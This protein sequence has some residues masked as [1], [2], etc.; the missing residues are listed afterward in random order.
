MD[1]CNRVQLMKKAQNNNTKQKHPQ[2]QNKKAPIKKPSQTTKNLSNLSV[3]F[4]LYFEFY[5]FKNVM[6]VQV[7]SR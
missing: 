5:M 1:F 4:Y 3:T 7:F 2:K 6:G